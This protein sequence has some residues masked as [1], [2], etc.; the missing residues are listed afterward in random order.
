MWILK[1]GFLYLVFADF[2]CCVLIGVDL[3]VC[4]IV[5]CPWTR[6]FYLLSLKSFAMFY[7]YLLSFVIIFIYFI[8]NLL[9]VF[10]L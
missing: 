2:V 7:H 6:L 4:A 1:A 3:C 8:I 9:I 10:G 5:V